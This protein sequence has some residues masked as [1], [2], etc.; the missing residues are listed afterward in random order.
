[1]SADNETNIS[2]E[3]MVDKLTTNELEYSCSTKETCCKEKHCVDC[4]KLIVDDEYGICAGNHRS[5]LSDNKAYLCSVHWARALNHKDPSLKGKCD[6]CC[7][8]EIT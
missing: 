2:R 7:W 5:G 8:W 1:M 6:Q 3:S 4:E